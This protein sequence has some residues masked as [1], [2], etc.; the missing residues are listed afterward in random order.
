MMKVYYFYW[1]PIYGGLAC[2]LQSIASLMKPGD[3]PQAT[4]AD[5][6]NE[7]MEKDLEKK[8]EKK[9]GVNRR[10]TEHPRMRRDSH[11]MS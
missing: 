10:H 8:R 6:E 2:I 7:Q 11:M 4:L 3:H 1:V 9:S 5:K